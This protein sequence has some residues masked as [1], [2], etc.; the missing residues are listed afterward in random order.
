MA[1]LLRKAVM[2]SEEVSWPGGPEQIDQR[3]ID[4]YHEFKNGPDLATKIFGLKFSKHTGTPQVVKMGKWDSSRAFCTTKK[5]ALGWRLPHCPFRIYDPVDGSYGSFRL[6]KQVTDFCRSYRD[7]IKKQPPMYT[8]DHF[9]AYVRDERY[10]WSTPFRPRYPH[11]AQHPRPSEPATTAR[12][13]DAAAG[14]QLAS[15]VPRKSV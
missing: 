1:L 10:L 12:A 9:D 6:C 13:V 7:E 4:D 14:R 8:Q 3:G 11:P 15:R 5:D 2:E